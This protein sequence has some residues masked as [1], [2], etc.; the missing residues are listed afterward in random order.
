MTS[1]R[2]VDILVV[3]H[4]RTEQAAEGQVPGRIEADFQQPDTRISRQEDRA[5]VAADSGDASTSVP[6]SGANRNDTNPSTIENIDVA[7]WA[8]VCPE[9]YE[10]VNTD[11]EHSELLQK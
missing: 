2:S 9:A 7:S 10:K 5:E 1:I 11:P 3:N 6:Q 4:V 8:N